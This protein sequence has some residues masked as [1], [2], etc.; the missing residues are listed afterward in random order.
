MH[1]TGLQA[2]HPSR[3]DQRQVV[4]GHR[5][6]PS[7]RPEHTLASYELALDLGAERIEPDI[8]LSKD[9]VL[10]ARHENEL[11]L[12]TDV[13]D[14]P[15]F[16]ARRRTQE[17]DDKE[18]TGWFTEDF[19]LAELRTLH[20]IERMPALRPLNTAYDG[21]YGI[22]TLGEVVSL[23]RRRSTRTRQ[24]RVQAELK[25]PSWW[26][27]QGLPMTELVAA[28]LRRLGAAGPDGSVVVQTF[29]AAAL[30][31]LRAELGPRGPE[32]VQLIS[33]KPRHDR[34][35][36]P[37]GLREIS[38]YAEAIG[39]GK[40]RILLRGEDDSLTGVSELIGQA[41]RAG[42]GVYSWT[43][44]PENAFLP[45]HLRGG[46][47]PAAHG[48]MQ[49]EARLLFALGIDG[50]ITD[51]PEVA[52]RARAELTAAALVPSRR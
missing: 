31:A 37:A 27:A 44:R 40:R 21:R 29:D 9:G 48:D 50:I 14:R 10:I 17:V 46:A 13:A 30:R 35:V 45:L 36:T 38:T 22:L 7:Y 32:Q 34:L 23:A 15:E 12:S 1:Q 26:A 20:A 51:A 3:H 6:A 24:V 33:D 47:D 25:Y 41:H 43:L 19:T 42:L 2:V 28:E 8:V 18:M 52:V 49:T 16:A 11:S 4:I 5:G 39:P